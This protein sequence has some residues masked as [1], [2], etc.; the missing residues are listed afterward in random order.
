MGARRRPTVPAPDPP[1]DHRDPGRAPG[2]GVRTRP[3]DRDVPRAA[4]P[5][6]ARPVGAAPARRGPGGDPARGHGRPQRISQQASW[7]C[8]SRA[9]WPSTWRSP[10]RPCQRA[11]PWSAAARAAVR[12]LR[13]RGGSVGWHRVPLSPTISSPDRRRPRGGPVALEPH[14]AASWWR[15]SHRGREVL[16]GLHAH[17]ILLGMFSDPGRN[18]LTGASVASGCWPRPASRV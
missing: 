3:G 18:R 1:G 5:A 6:R 9:V 17:E 4:G 7:S 15:C 2:T 10:A 12:R 13:R 8:R 14:R 16:R 11:A